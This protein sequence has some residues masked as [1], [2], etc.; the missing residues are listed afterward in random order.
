MPTTYTIEVTDA[1]QKA[2]EY[3][4]YSPQEWIENTIKDRANSSMKDIVISQLGFAEITGETF[5]GTVEEIVLNADIKT[6]A[7]RRNSINLSAC[8]TTQVE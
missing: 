5:S 4:F 2:L 7:E 1:Q 3:A 8:N 6:A